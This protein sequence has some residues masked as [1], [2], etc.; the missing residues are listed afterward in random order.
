MW[1]IYE[2]NKKQLKR[3]NIMIFLIVVF[4]ISWIFWFWYSMFQKYS[5]IKEIEKKSEETIKKI[6]NEYT[7][8]EWEEKKLDKFLKS[9]NQEKL[10]WEWERIEVKITENSD[11]ILNWLFWEINANTK[12]ISSDLTENMKKIEK[13]K[14][15]NEKI[16]EEILFKWDFCILWSRDFD[17]KWFFNSFSYDNWYLVRNYTNKMNMWQVEYTLY[18][19]KQT[20]IYKNPFLNFRKRQ[21]SKN[22][23]YW[24]N[25]QELLRY[26]KKRMNWY[27]KIEIIR[28]Q[29]ELKSYKWCLMK[30]NDWLDFLKYAKISTKMTSK[31]DLLQK[32]IIKSDCI[33]DKIENIFVF[34]KW[35]DFRKYYENLFK[36][37]KI[38]EQNKKTNNFKQWYENINYDDWISKF[39]NFLNNEK[40]KLVKENVNENKLNNEWEEIMINDI[41]YYYS[42]KNKWIFKLYLEELASWLFNKYWFDIYLN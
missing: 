32:W 15:K 7:E 1:V 27:S 10:E 31:E 19:F 36:S 23:T 11:D 37:K 39:V 9:S 4:V 20:Q 35:V 25:F 18:C 22:W 14:E 17:K 41:D 30:W 8:N 26:L 16:K 24:E 40:F 3:N 6:E 12:T 21:I 5:N 13:L 34:E 28:E 42:E 29:W 38:Y 33:I 2:E